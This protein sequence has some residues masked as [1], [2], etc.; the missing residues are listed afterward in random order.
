MARSFS[1]LNFIQTDKGLFAIAIVENQGPRYGIYSGWCDAFAFK[2]ESKGW[3][4]VSILLQAGG[5]GR[6]GYPGKYERMI[7]AGESTVGIVISSYMGHMGIEMSSE[8][9]VGLKDGNLELLAIISTDFT[10]DNSFGTP[11]VNIRN[12][13]HFEKKDK[14]EYDLIINQY[15]YKSGNPSKLKSIRIPYKNG[16]QIPDDY[17]FEA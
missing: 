13:Y 10:K 3:R 1:N 7:R 11:S 5:G 12:L 6:M 16:Y 9:I 4:L 8:S 14:T 17:M 2:K 15:D